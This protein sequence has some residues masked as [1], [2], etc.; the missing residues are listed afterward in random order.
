ML[1]WN[2]GGIKANAGTVFLLLPFSV[3][4]VPSVLKDFFAPSPPTTSTIH[5]GVWFA[6][7]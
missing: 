4:S 3:F 7:G 2:R 1:N 5:E 6:R